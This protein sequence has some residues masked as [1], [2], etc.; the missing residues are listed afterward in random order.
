M[1]D[2]I[3]N[4][5]GNISTRIICN[6][7]IPET[8]WHYDILDQIDVKIP[9]KQ[10]SNTFASLNSAQQ[11]KQYQG[12]EVWDS[13]WRRTWRSC[14]GQRTLTEVSCERPGPC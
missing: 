5:N 2:N 13:P 4:F 1:L 3:D 11:W 10:L 12:L 14:Y 8:F 9:I 6:L 7:I